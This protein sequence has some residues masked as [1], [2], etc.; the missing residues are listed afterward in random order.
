MAA[1]VV[2]ASP[3][4]VEFRRTDGLHIP[5]DD[6]SA[7]GL[8]CI[9]VLE[10]IEDPIPVVAEVA[11]VLKPGGL[12]VVTLD[13]D[14]RGNVD[15]G[16]EKFARVMGAFEERFERVVPERVIHPRRMLDTVTGPYPRAKERRVW[17]IM[18]RTSDGRML[19]LIG[20]PTVDEPTHLAVYGA[21]MTRRL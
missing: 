14:L 17:G 1:Q 21:A 2:N 4:R 6:A 3:G 20:G 8:F 12:F 7:D 5:V 18:F 16:P 11:R 19:P 10:H 15:I 13:V 9:S